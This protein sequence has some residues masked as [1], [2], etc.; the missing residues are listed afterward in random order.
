MTGERE[1][2]PPLRR[3]TLPAGFP[4]FGPGAGASSA[5]GRGPLHG[6]LPFARP[7]L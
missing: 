2:D 6:T 3:R 1:R 5:A 4:S 7:P